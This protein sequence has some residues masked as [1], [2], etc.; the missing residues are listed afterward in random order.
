MHNLQRLLLLQHADSFF[1]SGSSSFSW[2][3]EALAGAGRINGADSLR[4]FIAGQLRRRWRTFD[5][6]VLV[7]AR[8]A[9]HDGIDS[10]V[11]IDNLV[12]AQEL[13]MDIRDGSR[14][15]GQALLSM[16]ASL[17]TPGA[18]DYRSLVMGGQAH[19]HLPAMQG[20]LWGAIGLDEVD[21]VAMSGYA[22]SV[23]LASAALRLGL[24]GHIDVQK[25][26]SHCLLVIGDE[27]GQS[28]PDIASACNFTPEVDIA[29][30]RR[31][32]GDVRLFAN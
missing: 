32:E 26:L 9:A 4:E 31:D 1:P 12:E 2:G 14:R 7:S 16:H 20:M 22:F 8:K 17:G 5:R 6:V 25:T 11:H 19:G 10:V 21:C 15:N 24:V 28:E 27:L 13:V 3:L 18:A 30:S 29:V 23:S